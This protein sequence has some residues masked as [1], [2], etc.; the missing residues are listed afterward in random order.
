MIAKSDLIILMVSTTALVVGV[1]RWQ[2]GNGAPR[3]AAAPPP[4]V[5]RLA[6]ATPDDPA[7][8]TAVAG[9]LG[10]QGSETAVMAAENGAVRVRRLPGDGTGDADAAHGTERGAGSAATVPGAVPRDGTASSGAALTGASSAGAGEPLYGRHRIRSGDYL[11]KLATR[12]GTSVATLQSI[13]ELDG[14]TIHVGEELLYPM[15]A[16]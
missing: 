14:T 11:G 6:D 1:Y 13:N 4:P 3:I 8:A 9:S 15:P 16:N 2:Q 5:E 7:M 12:F 10:G